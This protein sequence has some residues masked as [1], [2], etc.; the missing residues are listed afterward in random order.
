MAIRNPQERY[1]PLEVHEQVQDILLAAGTDV[2]VDASRSMVTGEPDEVIAACLEPGPEMLP[3]DPRQRREALNWYGIG[4]NAPRLVAGVC[5]ED[6]AGK[7]MY[8][9]ALLFAR[10]AYQTER[11][12]P[13]PPKQHPASA[14]LVLRDSAVPD[15][16]FVDNGTPSEE[17]RHRRSLIITADP[18]RPVAARVTIKNVR[19]EPEFR[20]RALGDNNFAIE[21]PALPKGTPDRRRPIIV[22]ACQLPGDYLEPGLHE[23]QVEKRLRQAERLGWL[24]V[25]HFHGIGQKV[26]AAL[27]R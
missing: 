12:W 6:K 26:G 5:M 16:R 18:E 19:N 24:A 23:S 22:R 8:V 11:I 14:M 2:K 15:R 25:D 21:R 10:P 1:E 4:P 17:I 13:L 3:M 9:A 27:G 7:E 20:V